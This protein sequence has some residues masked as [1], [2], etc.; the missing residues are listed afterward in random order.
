MLV[1]VPR[2]TRM[3]SASGTRGH[4]EKQA[5]ALFVFHVER[6][7]APQVLPVSM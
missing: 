1:R 6:G 4:H 7:E 2:G 3:G 5:E